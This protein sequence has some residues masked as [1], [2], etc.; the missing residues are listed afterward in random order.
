MQEVIV[1]V[2]GRPFADQRSLVVGGSRGI[3]AVTARIIAAGGGHPIITYRDSRAEAELVAGDIR[4]VGG[5]CDILRYDVLLPATEQL[6]ALKSVDCCYY[7]ATPK[8]FLRKSGLF[9][10]DK[11]RSFLSFYADGFFDL[12]ATLVRDRSDTLAMFYPSTVAIEQ[13]LAATAEYAMAKSAGETL[14]RY[15]NEFMPHIEVLCRRLPRILTDQTATVGVASADNALDV[16]LAVVYEVQQMGRHEPAS[17][18]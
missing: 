12:C 3:G 5:S 9:E 16:M 10:A 11:L 15:L 1:R 4:S 7:F 18:R 8:I 6:R 2:S 17:L 14:A 13:G